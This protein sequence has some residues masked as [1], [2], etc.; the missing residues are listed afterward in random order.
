MENT[1][2]KAAKPDIANI[3]AWFECELQKESNTGSPVDARRELIRAL[4]IFSGISEKQIQESLEDLTRA[5]NDPHINE[6]EN[7]RTSK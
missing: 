3:I 7:E 6:T 2:Y 5:Q 1:E 4:A